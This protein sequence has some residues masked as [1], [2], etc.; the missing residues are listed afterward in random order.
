MH[1]S[2]LLVAAIALATLE[3][4]GVGAANCHEPVPLWG[5]SAK[6]WMKRH[7]AKLAEIAKGD[8][9]KIVFLGDLLAHE[10]EFPVVTREWKKY[11]AAGRYKAL[12]LGFNND[13]PET[14]LWRIDHGELDG[15]EAKVV[16]LELGT[17][18]VGTRPAIDVI[19]GIR[20]VL[21]RIAEKQP[22]A[23][24]ILHPIFPRGR[25]ADDPV[26][27]AS[28]TVNKELRHFADGRKV[29]W[30]DFNDQFTYADGTLPDEL[31]RQTLL[32]GGN[33]DDGGF[34][35]LNVWAAAILPTIERILARPEGDDT[36]L[37][38]VYP[39]HA[40]P[41]QYFASD[42]PLCCEPYTRWLTYSGARGAEWW[43]RRMLEKRREVAASGGRY[44]LVF[45]G[46]SITHFWEL[47][48][49]GGEAY[50]SI[51]NAYRTLNLG[52]GGDNTRQ[53]IWRL[54]NGE[55]EGYSAKMFML[56]I[57]TNNHWDKPKD[58]AAAT[59]KIMDLIRAKQPQ[60]KILLVAI[61]P[62][63]VLYRGEDVREHK[64]NLEVNE[65]IRTF[66]DGKDIWWLDCNAQYV[67]AQGKLRKDLFPD[68]IHPGP[69]G[70]RIWRDAAL[71]YFRKGVGR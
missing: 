57:G 64:R 33:S 56:M 43:G 51:T 55:L 50:A 58:I 46:D 10:W 1:M 21:R 61:P 60:A 40:S 5:D 41:A 53:V 20:E 2:K 30:I 22:K 19:L 44:D 12:N 54:T 34:D 28:E 23:V 42:N 71:P 36:V 45:V 52:Y 62:R 3:A 47:K 6:T 8:V 63:D 35:A 70:Y 39:A 17:H 38:N 49:H 66:A 69:A 7:E 14:V 24:T 13:R 29:V 16:V 4:F 59:R 15:Y 32:E 9:G 31:T 11:F 25:R 65:I 18:V 26:R 67:D 48:P 27:R 37:P 68:G